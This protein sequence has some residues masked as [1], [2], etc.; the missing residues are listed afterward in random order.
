MACSS[1]SG[2]VNDVSDSA[3]LGDGVDLGDGSD[4]GDGSDLGDG[5]DLGDGSGGSVDPGTGESV[6]GRLR[7]SADATQSPITPAIAAHLDA[8]ADDS[9][10]MN[11]FM[12]V[13]DSITAG[14]ANMTCFASAQPHIDH[15]LGDHSSLQPAIDFFNTGIVDS[16]ACDDGNAWVSTTPTVLGCS[17]RHNGFNRLSYAAVGGAIATLPLTGTPSLL[18]RE[19]DLLRPMLA[20]VQYGTNDSA[21]IHAAAD[22]HYFTDY[23]GHLAADVDA[24]IDRG[25]VPILETIPPKETFETT[26]TA[27]NVSTINAL[28]RMLAQSR[29]IPLV[30]LYRELV[31]IPRSGMSRY[32]LSDDGIHPRVVAPNPNQH[33]TYVAGCYFE[34]DGL[35]G[36]VNVRNLIQLTALDRARLVLAGGAAPDTAAGTYRGAGSTADPFVVDSLPFVD[37]VAA[38]DMTTPVYALNATV[39]A[40]FRIITLDPTAGSAVSFAVDGIAKSGLGQ[41]QLA[42]GMHS[43]TIDAPAGSA[44]ALAVIQLEDS[45]PTRE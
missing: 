8:I 37:T 42:I 45:D 33:A 21:V 12:K 7:Y 32:G 24:L 15:R 1:A 35:N 17:D 26:G 2:D 23:F 20:I 40:R 10:H 28:V 27:R 18:S 3:D 19:D 38:S 44:Y 16:S 11:M 25:I 9:R 13:G 36:G 31:T 29:S 22:Q 43:I 30:D 34:P 5:A 6:V 39:A 14:Y 41:A 4:V